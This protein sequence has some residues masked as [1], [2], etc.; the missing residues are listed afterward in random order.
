MQILEAIEGRRA[1]HYFDTTKRVSRDRLMELIEIANLAPSSFNL[2]PWRVVIVDDPEKKKVLRACALNQPKVEEASAVLII[3]A[4]P[5]AVEENMDRVLDSW[6]GLGYSK[7]EARQAYKDMALKLYGDKD[8][9][10]RKLFCTKNAALFAMTLMIAARGLGLE[11]HPMDGFEEECVK[12]EFGIPQDKIIP[13]L[14]A[15]GNLREGARLLPR[16]WRRSGQEFVSF[17][18]Y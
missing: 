13:M 14:I 11:T 5:L 1:I 2:Q 7:P 16:A 4:D 3:V 10:K 8:S 6:E 17:N 15:I 12:K 18:S 9:I